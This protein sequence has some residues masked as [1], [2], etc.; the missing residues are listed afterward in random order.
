MVSPGQVM[1]GGVVFTVMVRGASEDN[2]PLSVTRIVKRVLVALQSAT[3]FAVARPF[4]L[5]LIP[6]IVTPF[7]LA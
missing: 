4:E 1:V 5:T 6:E 7:V 3:M 2:P